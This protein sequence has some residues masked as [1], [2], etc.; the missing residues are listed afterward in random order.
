MFCVIGVTIKSIT[1]HTADG[2][3]RN[4]ALSQPTQ[5]EGLSVYMN[6]DWRA[7]DKDNRVEIA[8]RLVRDERLL[9]LSFVANVYCRM[10]SIVLSRTTSSP[11]AR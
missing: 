11:R 3:F 1:S 7:A 10:V 6:T 8:E 4:R 5:V 9:F 2:W